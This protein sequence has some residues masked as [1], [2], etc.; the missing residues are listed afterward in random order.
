MGREDCSKYNIERDSI[1]YSVIDEGSLITKYLDVVPAK[2]VFTP[3]SIDNPILERK[4]T[5]YDLDKLDKML[6]MFKT[7]KKES[8]LSTEKVLVQ[9][10]TPEVCLH[11]LKTTHE[12]L[13]IKF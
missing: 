13:G 3:Q 6:G 5:C 11:Y 12:C 7:D 1:R 9:L 4:D 8:S 10:E 2:D